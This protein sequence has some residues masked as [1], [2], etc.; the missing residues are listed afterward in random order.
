MNMYENYW[1]RHSMQFFHDSNLQNKQTSHDI[2]YFHNSFTKIYCGCSVTE[3]YFASLLQTADADFEGS[4]T[5]TL[6]N[7][8]TWMNEWMNV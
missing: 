8:W 7:D 2:L 1:F 5:D 6:I 4:S 3:N